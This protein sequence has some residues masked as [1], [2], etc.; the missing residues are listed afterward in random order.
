MKFAGIQRT[1]AIDF[2]KRLCSILF[3][4]GCMFRCH[5]CHNPELIEGPSPL[6]EEDIL[7]QLRERKSLV[8]AVSLTG[9][10]VTVHPGLP[11]FLKQLK[12]DEFEIKIDTNGTNPKM[13]K[14][15]LPLLDFIAMDVKAVD[16]EQ[17]EK[18][19][20]VPV[21]FENILESI[22]LIKNSDV[23]YEFRIT[24]VPA[25]FSIS[26]V[27][28]LGALLKG[29]KKL[30]IQQFVPSKTLNPAFMKEKPFSKEDLYK[31]QSVLKEYIDDVEIRGI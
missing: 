22:D 26:R 29:T 11:S 9:G 16:K 23:E 30:V 13:L 18:T 3:T 12:D 4:S 2:P 6:S 8:N 14:E 1:S 10:E 25:L 17:Y 24:V 5:Y 19:V 28:E 15:I 20:G 31:M 7:K 27:S 21:K